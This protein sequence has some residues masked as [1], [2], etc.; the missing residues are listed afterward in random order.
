[1]V[2]LGLSIL[3]FFQVVM[4]VVVQVPLGIF[5]FWQHYPAL[6]KYELRF[7]FDC[8]LVVSKRFFDPSCISPTLYLYILILPS[9]REY[10]VAKNATYHEHTH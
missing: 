1:M 4:A 6:M 9:P 8:L 2:W 7:R 3:G 10:I 5:F